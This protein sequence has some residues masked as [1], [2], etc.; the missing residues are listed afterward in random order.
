M[1]EA[2]FTPEPWVMQ[3][4]QG[5]SCSCS[6]SFDF[7][8]MELG[9]SI[10]LDEFKANTALIESAP[11]LYQILYDLRRAIS[12]GGIGGGINNHEVLKSIDHQLAKSRGE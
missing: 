4:S 3:E 2:K 7:E 10:E 5:L 8:A 11:D 9:S 6:W 12:L 1:S